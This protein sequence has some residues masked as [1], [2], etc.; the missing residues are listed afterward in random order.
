[1]EQ[2]QPLIG[3]QEYVPF[4][5]DQLE[6]N[7]VNQQVVP[8][9]VKQQFKQ[10]LKD[11]SKK[12]EDRKRR[13]SMTNIFVNIEKQADEI[14]G[15]ERVAVSP[16]NWSGTTKA[17]KKHK[18]I[19]NPFA[20]SWWMSKRKKGDKWGPGGKLK[21][22]P[23]PHY[24]PEKKSS[25]EHVSAMVEAIIQDFPGID[26]LIQE[27]PT[28]NSSK[29]YSTVDKLQASDNS[30]ITIKTN[31]KEENGEP[32][33][34]EYTVEKNGDVQTYNDFDSFQDRMICEGLL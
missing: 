25:D 26:Q 34:E 5:M 8:D 18:E 4:G 9:D 12:V 32:L 10:R 23:Q 27:P 14:L 16:Q 7:F 28:I 11:E 24:K 13:C 33:L 22:K 19:D 6:K 3:Q 21:K 20:L 29:G 2:P 31:Y 30:Y 15:V 1:M 17:M